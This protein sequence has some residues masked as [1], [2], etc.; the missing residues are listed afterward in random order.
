MEKNVQ[1]SNP[2]I[3]NIKELKK[4]ILPD[5]RLILFGSQAR[6]DATP[7]SDWDILI[8]LDKDEIAPNDFEKYAYPFVELGWKLGEY[9]SMKLYTISEWMKRQGTPF[10]KN[11]ESEGVE[12]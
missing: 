2:I 11:V 7:E 10:F 12:L 9:F 5:A 3:S 6:Q 4:M 1:L 8:L